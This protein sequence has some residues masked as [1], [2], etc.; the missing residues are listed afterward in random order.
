MESCVPPALGHTA[1]LFTLLRRAP[2][3]SCPLMTAVGTAPKPFS[4]QR[5]P[6]PVA[7][8]PAQPWPRSPVGLAPAVWMQSQHLPLWTLTCRSLSLQP[9]LPQ[10]NC[11]F[12]VFPPIHQP[13]PLQFPTRNSGSQPPTT[14]PSSAFPQLPPA[15]APSQSSGRGGRARGR[16]WRATSSSRGGGRLDSP[17]ATG[18][19]AQ[20]ASLVTQLGALTQ[21][22]RE[23]RQ[24]NADLRRQL[25]AA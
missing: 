19:E 8:P 20:V 14:F 7:S 2:L 9:S 16:G 24:E 17:T 22:I 23:L 1:A 13:G 12:P 15:S 11:Q 21:E 10:L 5:N 18:L 4:S 3:P 25:A 6:L